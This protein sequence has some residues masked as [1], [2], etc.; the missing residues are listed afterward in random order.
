MGR[1]GLIHF[2][3]GGDAGIEHQAAEF[4]DA[5]FVVY[6]GDNHAAGIDAHHFSGW[7]VGDGE[8]GLAEQ[9][10]GFVG[11]VNPAQDDPVNTCAVV[12]DEFQKLFGLFD[13]LAFF[14]LD[15]AEVRF[16]KGLEVNEILKERLN[17]ALPKSKKF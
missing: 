10:F 16:G 5:V 15:G 12:E 8:E 17:F 14:D 13:C 6:G 4:F 9:F 7:Q 11:F 3:T 2:C 1:T